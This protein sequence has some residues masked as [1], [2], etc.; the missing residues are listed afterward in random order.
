MERRELGGRHNIVH[1]YNIRIRYICACILAPQTL[2]NST[3]Q[4][5]RTMNDF[6]R[7]ALIPLGGSTVIC[8]ELQ[9]SKHCQI[10]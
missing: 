2:N 8:G 9:V 1:Y 7:F 3:V 4:G 10:Q 5:Q 6:S